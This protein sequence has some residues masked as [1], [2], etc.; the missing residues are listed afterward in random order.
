MRSSPLRESLPEHDIIPSG[1][2]SASWPTLLVV[3]DDVEML[4]ALA[5]YFEKRG[6]HVAASSNLADAK[7]YFHRRKTWTL[8][9]ADYHLPDGTG[10]ELCGW[11]RE[12]GR[13]TPPFLLM[14]GSMNC[15][16]AIEGV[17]VLAKPFPLEVLEARVRELVG[18]V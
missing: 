10:L 1:T 8:V 6:F 12:Q 11:I 18:A 15:V 16:T 7:T 17:D 13:G 9:I 3:D 5:W 4:Q 14:S 2:H